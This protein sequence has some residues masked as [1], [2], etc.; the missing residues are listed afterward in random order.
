MPVVTE[1]L[2]L[3]CSE[4]RFNYAAG[5]K[6]VPTKFL[7]PGLVSYRDQAGGKVELLRKET[8]DEA[9]ASLVGVPVTIGHVQLEEAANLDVANGHVSNPR[10]NADDGWYWCD[11][12]VETSAARSK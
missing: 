3:R 6:V 1:S 2:G 7:T 11:S 12:E 10:F 8:I 9:L 4:G 5:A